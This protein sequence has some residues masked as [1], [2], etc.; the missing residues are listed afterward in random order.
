[1]LDA[2]FGEWGIAADCDDYKGS[3]QVQNGQEIWGRGDRGG[4]G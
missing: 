2:N 3:V 1:M 4:G